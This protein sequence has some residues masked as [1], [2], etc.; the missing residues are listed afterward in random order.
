MKMEYLMLAKVWKGDE[1]IGGWYCS[2]KMDGIRAFWDGGVSIGRDI[3]EVGWANPIGRIREATGLWSRYGKVLPAPSSWTDGLPDHPLDG[4]LWG[5]L[6]REDIVSMVKTDG[7]ASWDGVR[8]WAFDI[9]PV[10]GERRT[11][12][13]LG[14]GAGYWNCEG[15]EGDEGMAFHRVVTKLAGGGGRSWVAVPQERLPLRTRDAEIR[16]QERLEEVTARGGE[17]LMLRRGASLYQY[18]R[19]GD[20]LKVK[21]LHDA[22]ATVIGYNDGKGRLTGML[23]GLR[24]RGEG[25]VEFSV[26]GI[27]DSERRSEL[28]PLGSKIT[29][30]YRGL[31]KKGV[32]V[33]A[34]YLRRYSDE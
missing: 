14:T 17:G 16:V 10:G 21:K 27:K 29:Y 3:S 15:L 11:I 2:E 6:P 5:D 18:A 20:L 12:R 22:E 24:V 4:E 23:G 26:T 28:F 34:R 25:G 13:Q 8:L 31:T 7:R 30:R 19:S 1:W 33:E 9:P 32:P